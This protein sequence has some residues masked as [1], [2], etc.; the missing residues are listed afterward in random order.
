MATRALVMKEAS[1]GSWVLRAAPQAWVCLLR[2]AATHSRAS[3]TLAGTAGALAVAWASPSSRLRS[4]VKY[5]SAGS[6]QLYVADGLGARGI[7]RT[8][9]RYWAPSEAAPAC[10]TGAG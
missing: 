2:Q 1:C 5:V 4:T 7:L 9:L 10:A 8:S 6:C 3:A